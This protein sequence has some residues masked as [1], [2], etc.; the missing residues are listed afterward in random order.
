MLKLHITW[1]DHLNC[2]CFLTFQPARTGNA[3]GKR[4][5][6]H[7]SADICPPALALM[8]PSES[9]PHLPEDR[10][11]KYKGENREVLSS[12]VPQSNVSRNA[13]ALFTDIE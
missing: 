6:S 10:A 2:H 8:G 5:I 4:N 1:H 11:G 12:S 3:R 13:L 9:K 7:R